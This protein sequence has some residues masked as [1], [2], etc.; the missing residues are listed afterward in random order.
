MK[1]A[2]FSNCFPSPAAQPPLASYSDKELGELF[3]APVVASSS[4]P[5]WPLYAIATGAA[6][7]WL[8][9]MKLNRRDDVRR[10]R[11]WR[12]RCDRCAGTH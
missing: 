12:E 10:E 8:I 7:G 1:N 3:G 5:L 11:P 9:G 2:V 4:P 6:C